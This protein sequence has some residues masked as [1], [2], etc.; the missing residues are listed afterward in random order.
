MDNTKQGNNVGNQNQQPEEPKKP[1]ADQMT[2]LLATAAGALTEGAVRTL[3]KRVRKTA[4]KTPAP[5]KKAAQAVT[6]AAK[7]PKTAKK[8]KKAAKPGARKKAA[9]KAR[10]S[11]PKKGA[12]MKATKAKKSNRR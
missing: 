4:A 11:A 1:I 6:K 8:A 3:A 10:K 9:K 7:T 5:L 2:D 12:K